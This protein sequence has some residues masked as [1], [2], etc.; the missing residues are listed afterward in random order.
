MFVFR[1]MRAFFPVHADIVIHRGFFAT[2]RVT[3][4]C[5]DHHYYS[6]MLEYASFLGVADTLSC[7]TSLLHLNHSRI[8]LPPK[9][10]SSSAMTE[11]RHR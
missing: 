11:Q 6:E 2:S 9:S 5:E 1:M 10:D 4:A 8:K 7:W 3:N